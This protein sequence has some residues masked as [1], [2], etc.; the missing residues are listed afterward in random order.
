MAFALAALGSVGWMTRRGSDTAKQRDDERR[1]AAIRK[2]Q[3]SQEQKLREALRTFPA[4]RHSYIK[5][6]PEDYP[7]VSQRRAARIAWDMG[8]RA[9]AAG[10]RGSWRLGETVVEEV[11]HE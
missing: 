3:A 11:P 2:A 1:S 8:L 9:E 10:S 6:H 5:V 7:D 4:D